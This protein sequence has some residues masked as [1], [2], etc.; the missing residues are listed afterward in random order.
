MNLRGLEDA[1]IPEMTET[2]TPEGYSRHAAFV[3]ELGA[4]LLDDLDPRPGEA[5]SISGAA[6][7]SCRPA[8]RRAA[9]RR[10]AAADG[11]RRVAG[12]VCRIDPREAAAR[13]EA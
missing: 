2:W 9:R 1:T 13:S 4:A 3:P 8:L 6:T 12:N 10:S 11:N 5:F 7:A